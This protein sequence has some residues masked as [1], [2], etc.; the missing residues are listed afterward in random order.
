[1]Q[2]AAAALGLAAGVQALALPL[3]VVGLVVVLMAYW[4]RHGVTALWWTTAI[5]ALIC[6]P[7]L[8]GYFV[9]WMQTGSPLYPLPLTIAGWTIVPGNEQLADVFSGANLNEVPRFALS[10]FAL[11]L[12]HRSASIDHLNFGAGAILLVV[13]GVAGSWP[14]SSDRHRRVAAILLIAFIV[15]PV[16][17]IM[18]DAMLSQRTFFAPIVGRLIAPSLAA[19][20]L[21]GSI[22]HGRLADWLRTLAV[23][24]G[25]L[26]AMPRAISAVESSAMERTAPYIA[27]GT[28]VLVVAGVI[29]WRRCRLIPALGV[30]ALI[31][32]TVVASGVGSIRAAFRFPIYAAAAAPV[33]APYDLIPLSSFLVVPQIWERLDQPEPLRIAFA[34]AWDGFNGHTSFRYPLLGRR[35]QNTLIYVPATRDGEV[36]DYKQLAQ[37]L[38]RLDFRVWLRRLIEQRIAVVVVSVPGAPEL[39]WMRR[40]PNAFVPLGESP[41]VWT[42][43]FRFDAAEAQA[44]SLEPSRGA[45]PD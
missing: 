41:G 19:I 22:V 9:A 5:S 11:D 39:D 43:A 14:L 40:H 34:A 17:G 32:L 26:Y 1:V 7:M 6:A 42:W 13:L 28:I 33:G 30:G 31:G 18:S 29:G 16:A 3:L 24:I 12:F 23:L 2:L 4:W 21:M 15:I 37:L 10:T 20:A 36:I 27:G 44:M 45:M 25:A 8:T 38:P 35:L